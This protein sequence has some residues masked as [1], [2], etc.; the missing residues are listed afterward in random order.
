MKNQTLSL[1][2][3]VLFVTNIL[4][5]TPDNP[6]RDFKQPKRS[7]L[8]FIENKGQVHDQDNRSRPD[9]L[10]GVMAGNMAVHIKNSGVSYQLYRV[11]GQKTE[12][13]DLKRGKRAPSLASMVKAAGITTIY[14]IDLNWLNR[15][16]DFTRTEDEVLPG[17]DNYYLENCPEGVLNVKSYSGVTLKN[18]YKGI[19]LHYYEKDGELKHDYIVAP[20]ADYKQIRVQVEGAELSLNTDG[21]LLL[22]T[23]LGQVQEGAPLVYQNGTQLT[24]RWLITDNIL[25]FEVDNYNPDSELLIDPL[26]RM[27]GTYYG[28]GGSDVSRSCTTDASGNIYFCGETD[29][30][31][32]TT[33]ATTGSHQSTHGGGT[34]GS[35]D[36]YLAKFNTSG[37]RLWGTYYGGGSF[38]IGTSCAT[39]ANGNVF[40]VGFTGSTNNIATFGSHQPTMSGAIWDAFLV[41]FS[42]AGSRQWGTYYGG[43]GDD[44]AYSCAADANGDVYVAGETSTAAANI[45]STPGSHQ[46]VYGG[47]PNFFADGFLVKFSANGVRQWGTYYGDVYEDVANG[48]T[49]DAIGDVYICGMA[50]SNAIGVMSTPGSHQYGYNGAGDA[51]L[52]K[53]DGSGARLW[54]TYYGGS[55]T[56]YGQSCATDPVSNDVFLAGYTDSN[57]S[58]AIGSTGCHQPAYGGGANDAFLVKFDATGTR[59]WGTYY[60][61]VGVDNAWSVAV[62][63]RGNA[64]MCG[65]TTLNTGTVIGTVGSHQPAFGGGG[66]AIL[67]KFDAYGVRQWGTYYGGS[68]GD[69][70]LG[71]AT[72]ANDNLF[73]TGN[74]G[75]SNGLS[76]IMFPY[77]QSNFGGGSGD[78]FLVKFCNTPAQPLA[79]EGRTAACTGYEHEYTITPVPEATGYTWSLPS[80]WSGTSNTITIL[81]TPGSSGIFTVSANGTC[82]SSPNRTLSVTVG[83]CTGINENNITQQ[84]VKLYPNPTPGI[85]RL[86]LTS[87]AEIVIMNAIGQTVY[88]ARHSAGDGQLNLEHLA[89][90][91]YVVKVDSGGK[92]EST[93]MVKE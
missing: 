42:S 7:G 13:P 62:D 19:N 65:G 88:S 51:Y 83:D 23:P 63:K 38:D 47:G 32:G 9:V 58:T 82:G 76:I 28:G 24:A 46:Q 29:L 73:M 90:G 71:C 16:P 64:F 80:S 15:N 43:Q 81:A 5:K 34:S 36:A 1:L 68:N 4:A 53:F 77:H 91:V 55:G 25:S 2:I 75:S 11:D 48:C 33:I 40:L 54:A 12:V 59:Y 44:A 31:T 60:G 78:A 74:T 52:A 45:I 86:E 84:G 17:Y 39:D 93:K 57:T 3:T 35:I 89:K 20:H 18:L 10:Y 67:V 22:S 87:A 14:R 85:V 37:T 41:K 56:D 27:W 49:T 21:S 61:G 50:G 66:D 92:S 8:S 79:I 70:A 26:T 30:Q 69:G 72:D 6:E